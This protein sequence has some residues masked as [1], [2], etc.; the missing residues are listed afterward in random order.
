MPFWTPG[1]YSFG[2]EPA[3]DLGFELE[4]VAFF[5]RFEDD[6]DAREL[7]GTTG[8]L[9]VRVVFFVTLRDRHHGKQPAARRRWLQP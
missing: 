4:V 8:L 1:M 7:T 6:L 2:I 3:N 5:V 9:L